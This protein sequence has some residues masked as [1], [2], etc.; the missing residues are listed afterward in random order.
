MPNRLTG[1]S[2][3]YLEQHAGQP[4]DWHPWGHDAPTRAQQ[5]DRPILLS[6]GYAACYGCHV[7][8]RHAFSDEQIA[9]PVFAVTPEAYR[10]AAGL[11]YRQSEGTWVRIR[12]RTPW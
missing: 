8:A 5:E 2:S 7:I 6:I 3:I 12:C 1:A 4:V 10:G 9:A 11:R